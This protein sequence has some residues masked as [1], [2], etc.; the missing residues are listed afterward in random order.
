[1]QTMTKTLDA[2]QQEIIAATS[3]FG[4]LIIHPEK[5][6]TMTSPFLGFP[7]SN[8]FILKPHGTESPFM[9]LQS[10]D[11]PQLAFV[12]TPAATLAPQYQPAILPH[13][14]QELGA[15]ESDSL[16]IFLIL[17]I[18]GE[19]PLKMTANLL[20]PVMIN[21]RTRFAKQVVQDPKVFDHRWPVFVDE[22]DD[23]N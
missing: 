14:R 12:V 5:I 13:V 21:S 8:R 15:E 19:N 18:P 11:D 7:D 2:G 10:L 17:T 22:Q 4:N 3:R 9:W 16:E 6:I 23:I 20:G 1:V